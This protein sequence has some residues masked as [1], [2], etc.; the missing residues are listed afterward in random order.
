MEPEEEARLRRR[1][2]AVCGVERAQQQLACASERADRGIAAQ[3]AYPD[4]AD[5]GYNEARVAFSIQDREC[6]RYER[7]Y[8][9]AVRRLI[10]VIATNPR[11]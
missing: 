3:N 6:S 4:P 9:N 7:R 2:A 5:D 1:E 10:E 11:V 8:T